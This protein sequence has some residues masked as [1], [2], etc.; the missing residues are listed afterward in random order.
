MISTYRKMWQHSPIPFPEFSGTRIMMMPVRIGYGMGV[1][2]NYVGIFTQLSLMAERRFD[3]AIGYLTIDERLVQKDATLRRPGLHVD[4]YYQGRCGA[5]GGG[6]GWGS[7]GNGMLTVSSTPHCKAYLGYFSEEPGPEG[8]CGHMT[9]PNEGEIFQANQ[10][11]WLD[12][13]CVHESLPVEEDTYR[14]FVRLSLPSNGP[15]FEG[16]TENPEGILPSNE[17]LPKRIFS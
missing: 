2:E 16:Y 10:V 9:L 4:G 8:E 1:P 17:I 7:V 5:W 6:G 13:A 12:G 3:G 15:W 11:Y 14:Q